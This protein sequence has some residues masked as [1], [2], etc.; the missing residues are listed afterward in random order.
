MHRY[1]VRA[2]T[3]TAWRPADAMVP[4]VRQLAR[5]ALA[6]SARLCETFSSSFDVYADTLLPTAI[7]RLDDADH[8]VREAAMALLLAFVGVLGVQEIWD[9]LRPALVHRS[10]QARETAL[11][12]A[13]KMLAVDWANPLGQTTV[14]FTPVMPLLCKLLDDPHHDVRESAVAVLGEIHRRM[15]DRLV[16]DLKRRG[17]AHSRLQ[18]VLG[19]LSNA[20]GAD[21]GQ[22]HAQSSAEAP[23]AGARGGRTGARA[24]AT[25]SVGTV[26]RADRTVRSKTGGGAAKAAGAAE[27]AAGMDGSLL[28]MAEF[29]SFDDCEPVRPDSERALQEE[30]RKIA[31][32]VGNAE[33][34]WERRAAGLRRVRSLLNGGCAERFDS[35]AGLVR[36]LLRDPMTVSLMDLRSS[37]LR[38][39]CMTLAHL[40]RE[41][42]DRLEPLATH[43]VAILMRATYASVRVMAEAARLCILQVLRCLRS[44][45]LMQCVCDTYLS[46][47]SSQQRA[48]CVTCLYRVLTV[49]DTDSLDR[50]S[51][52]LT[53]VLRRA[54][55]DADAK[56]RQVARRSFWEF[57]NRFSDAAD[58]LV[59]SL[60]GAQCKL[61]FEERARRADGSGAG[62]NANT[63]RAS[64]RSASLVSTS[65]RMSGDE[66]RLNPH[67]WMGESEAALDERPAAAPNRAA[68]ALHAPIA[69]S[70]SAT[71]SLAGQA[72]PVAEAA[73]SAVV[74]L[75][76][77]RPPSSAPATVA[78]D[79]PTAKPPSVP[80]PSPP[81]S[82]GV[83]G[84]AAPPAGRPANALR[85]TGLQ[86]GA[87]RTATPLVMPATAARAPTRA[88]D[89][90]AAGVVVVPA[91]SGDRAIQTG[92]LSSANLLVVRAVLVR[93]DAS[94]AAIRARAFAELA[95]AFD[96]L[97]TD[98]ARQPQLHQ[99]LRDGLLTC[100]RHVGDADTPTAMAAVQCTRHLL[101]AFTR[102]AWTGDTSWLRHLFVA[103]FNRLASAVGISAPYQIAASGLLDHIRR[104]AP[105]A[106]SFTEL[107]SAFRDVGDAPAT[108]QAMAAV[109]DDLAG[110]LDVASLPP[111]SQDMCAGIETLLAVASQHDASGGGQWAA[112]AL[113]QLSRRQPAW[114]EDMLGA[115]PPT[116][117]DVARRICAKPTQADGNGDEHPQA[118]TPTRSSPLPSAP[119]PA[120]PGRSPMSAS[121][122]PVLRTPTVVSRRASPTAPALSSPGSRIPVPIASPA[123]IVRPAASST[124]PRAAHPPAHRPS[125]ERQ[126]TVT[127]LDRIVHAL[128]VS[129]TDAAA[130][131]EREA[132]LRALAQY[133]AND[134][135]AV[136]QERFPEIWTMVLKCCEDAEPRVRE[137]AARTLG[138]MMLLHVRS[139]VVPRDR[140]GGRHAS[141]GHARS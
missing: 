49:W 50:V 106:V 24:S 124:P 118:R 19:Y 9:R 37:V 57:A 112:S 136:W 59:A 43:C 90:A 3:A 60:D 140:S 63:S 75:A 94:D 99:L 26:R 82:H 18:A 128:A 5:I 71:A 69:D 93:C 74:T 122:I 86:H 91:R 51:G 141:G 62:T 125:P 126:S 15:G 79:M 135:A 103:L 4:A 129:D 101:D 97:G 89:E 6:A 111:V 27:S 41:L 87:L 72:R 1:G 48:F 53:T 76:N 139:A 137:S 77:G 55:V 28:S 61:L 25:R 22:R 115:L 102:A 66:D 68:D 21:Q 116:W 2:V 119:N 52:L 83:A 134:N 20:A 85:A 96:A 31:A 120:T 131:H 70:H 92:A 133:T 35:F 33:C 117:A 23:A 109:L 81:P 88:S 34:D 130:I 40:A 73:P 107:L 8:T 121:R 123:S 105:V 7:G 10:P 16:E 67:L 42:G 56:T 80:R 100:A 108:S 78:V 114:F 30:C 36:T 132:A 84:A 29:E 17:I 45:K 98:T 95:A 64:T 127:S 39:G 58:A 54:L 12:L 11:Q 46:G 32:T 47:K 44:P 65:D 104:H 38:D 14:Q 13:S 113:R 138:E 110:T